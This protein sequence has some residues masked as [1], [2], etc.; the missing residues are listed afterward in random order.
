MVRE[1]L[2]MI[3]WLNWRCRRQYL[4]NVFLTAVA[5]ACITAAPLL[6]ITSLLTAPFVAGM[7]DA[8]HHPL[9]VSELTDNSTISGMAAPVKLFTNERQ[10]LLLRAPLVQFEG[11]VV[12]PQ[13]RQHLV[14]WSFV[15]MRVVLINTDTNDNTTQPSGFPRV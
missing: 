12:Q 1:P 3:D 9:R 8:S 4:S 11:I 15:P 7:A 5:G 2:N 6:L 14:R 13:C 10:K